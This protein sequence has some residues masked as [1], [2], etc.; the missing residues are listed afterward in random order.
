MYCSDVSGAFDKV[1]SAKLLRKL[2][3]FGVNAQIVSVI[4]SWLDDRTASVV[5]EGQRSRV[6]AM[7]NMIFQGTVWGPPL[8]NAFYGDARTAIHI[9]DLIECIFAD[10]LNAYK[11]FPNSA[12]NETLQQEMVICQTNLHKWGVGN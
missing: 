11:A 3:K 1:S 4:K 7:L 6:L 10:D 8:W 5:V 2:I 12:P 9:N